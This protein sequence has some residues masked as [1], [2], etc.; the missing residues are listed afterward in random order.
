MKTFAIGRA[1][2]ARR[3]DGLVMSPLTQQERKMIFAIG[4]EPAP[5][6]EKAGP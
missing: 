2:L 4:S 6:P 5:T 1:A 3:R